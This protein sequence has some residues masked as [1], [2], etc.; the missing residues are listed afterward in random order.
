MSNLIEGSAISLLAVYF[1]LFASVVIAIFARVIIGAFR[2][3]KAIVEEYK[4]ESRP[5]EDRFMFAAFWMA[6]TLLAI[7]A[8]LMKG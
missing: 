2:D 5:L 4:K 1:L 7:S 6:V 8:F 3:G